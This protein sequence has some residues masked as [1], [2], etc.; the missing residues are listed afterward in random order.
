MREDPAER[1]ARYISTV[2]SALQSMKALKLGPAEVGQP[3]VARVIDSAERY[4]EDARF[5]LG[6][7][8]AVTAL[9][10][11]A[12]CEGLVDSLH[13]LGLTPLPWRRRHGA[14]ST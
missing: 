6:E 8:K 2:A 5:Y 3:D 7:G 11:V 14:P 4:L 12:Y 13:L 9:A 1:A 10:S